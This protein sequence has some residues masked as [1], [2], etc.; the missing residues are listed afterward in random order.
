[1][2]NRDLIKLL[3]DESMDLDVYVGGIGPLED[4]IVQERPSTGIVYIVVSP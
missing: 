3:L 2:K 4:V 1:M